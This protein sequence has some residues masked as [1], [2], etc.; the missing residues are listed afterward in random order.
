V[1]ST[2]VLAVIASAGYLAGAIIDNTIA[3]PG[4]AGASAQSFAAPRFSDP[5]SLSTDDGYDTFDWVRSGAKG[6]EAP[7]ECDATRGPFSECV[8]MD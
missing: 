1:H 8:F 4:S 2:A 5:P 6:V 3:I 7:R